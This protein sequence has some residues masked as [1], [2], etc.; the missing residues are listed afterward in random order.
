MKTLFLFALLS[1]TLK[2]TA[3]S[4]ETKAYESFGVKKIEI[5]NPKG[6]INIIGSPGL[7]KIMVSIDK[8][9]F[10]KQCT[11]N[12]TNTLGV[13]NA[14]VAHEAMFEKANCVTKLKVEVPSNKIFSFDVTTGTANISMID[15]LGSVEFKTATGSVDI[16]G[17]SLKN[18]DGKTATSNMH[19]TFKK[20]PGRAD[21]DLVTATGDSEI[22]L[23]TTCKIKVTHKS[24]MG[25]LFN[26]LGESED[27]QVHINSKSA[28]G[29]LKIKKLVK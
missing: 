29:S 5:T 18:I 9:H 17:E 21:I 3:Y 23:P 7:K 20:C 22:V 4:A 12:I 1:L 27:Y 16:K 28:N 25:E 6:E 2:N 11:F 15:V 24:A 8:I 19:I 10:D 26:E 13:L 14:E